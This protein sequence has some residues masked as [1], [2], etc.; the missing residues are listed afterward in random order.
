MSVL[1]QLAAL[2][3]LRECFAAVDTLELESWPIGPG[4][5]LCIAQSFSRTKIIDAVH[6]NDYNDDDGLLAAISANTDLRQL[7][8]KLKSMVPTEYHRRTH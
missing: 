3:P 7:S 8:I 4:S 1:N 2:A 5:M 6:C